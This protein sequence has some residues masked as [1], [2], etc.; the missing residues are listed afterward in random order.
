MNAPLS[1]S[2][3][4]NPL[5]EAWDDDFGLPPFSNI[6]PEH[7]K[8]A[9]EI[10]LAQHR[11]EL[12]SIANDAS[13]ATFE[14]TVVAF[15]VAGRLFTRLNLL[16][17]NLSTSATTDELQAI[18]RDLA[19]PLAA[20]AN[21]IYLDQRL[22]ARIDAVFAARTSLELNGE[23]MRLVERIHLD[24]LRAGA[25]LEG[26]ARERFAEVSEQLALHYT[27]FGQNV[28]GDETGYQLVLKDDTDL[29]GLPDFLR[30]AA[31]AAAAERGIA[32]G[33]V[34]TLSRSLIVPF[35]TYSARRDLRERA[36]KAWIARGEG[37]FDSTRDNRALIK[38]IMQ[39]RHEQATLLGF[40][41]YTAYALADTMAG[42]AAAVRKL[43]DQ[44]WK[45]ACN[46]RARERAQLQTIIDRDAP[47]QTLEPWDWR[48]Y[49]EKVRAVDY[50]LD[51][52]A[53]KPYFSLDRMVEAAFD[54]ANRLFGLSF[55]ARTDIRAYHPDVKVYEVHAHGRLKAIFL[56]DNFARPGKRSGAWM[57]ILRAQR[58]A[59][60][61]AVP[62]VLNNNN[63][64][65]GHPTLL[66]FEDVRT[67]FHEFGHGLHGMLSDVTY[68]RLA[69]TAVLRDFVELPSQIYEHWAVER[70]VLKRHARHVETGDAIPDAFID[71]L[72][73]AAKFN[74]GFE[75]VEYCAS[76]L[77][78][79][80]LHEQSDFAEF[81][82]DTFER[83]ELAR[84]GMPDGAVMRHRLP[85]FLHLFSRASY[86]S[87][88][89]VY[90]WAEVLDCDAFDAFKEAGSAFDATTAKRLH[91]C[92]Y[93]VGN[94]REPGATFRAFR[95]R[96]PKVEAMLE[97]RG[98]IA[99]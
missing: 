38:T 54:C 19:Q 44:T 15:D 18:E 55:I 14:N 45:P 51:N 94:T 7:F 26:R 95:G 3:L 97:S 36:F 1:A 12:T 87:A 80:A 84:I 70:E 71:K 65:K 89:Y 83:T 98:L 9:F 39:L 64:A 21:A 41:N 8:P 60:G 20:H 91:D 28:L 46:R 6:R 66:S 31:R 37:A 53:I 68:E 43:L 99:A 13:P 79:L 56:H 48:F 69:G 72:E 88:Y 81:D 47:G 61:D 33:H 63:F 23:Q 59:G 10:A 62:I 96:D 16:F 49:A 35:L 25:K 4:A 5:L 17:D 27:V 73:A 85:H 57:S 75:T 22:F 93:S 2:A 78:D 67:L 30:D 34:I 58:R 52:A 92:V 77:V 40:A 86:A 11:A 42:S 24:F 50:A 29:A 32:N 82:V 90:L 76:T 74:Q